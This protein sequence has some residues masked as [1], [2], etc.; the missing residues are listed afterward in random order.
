[1][2]QQTYEQERDKLAASQVG[3]G[4]FGRIRNPFASVPSRIAADLKGKSIEEQKQIIE[5]SIREREEQG[6]PPYPEI[7]RLKELIDFIDAQPE[8]TEE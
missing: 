1:M 2:E 5:E 7:L 6:Q 3:V 4:R 8:E